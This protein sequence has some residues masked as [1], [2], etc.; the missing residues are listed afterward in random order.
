MNFIKEHAEAINLGVVLTIVML[1]IIFGL[2]VH[3]MQQTYKSMQPRWTQ[4]QFI[5]S[6]G[7][8]TSPESNTV[9]DGFVV[10]TPGTVTTFTEE[11]GV[12]TTSGKKIT[13]AGVLP[14]NFDCRVRFSALTTGTAQVVAYKLR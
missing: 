14:E 8:S 9:W 5:T 10:V 13:D 12:G 3:A 7:S 1:T 2:H 6:G 11:D 4:Y